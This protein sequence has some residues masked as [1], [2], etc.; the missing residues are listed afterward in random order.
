MADDAR[1]NQAAWDAWSVEYRAPNRASWS[2][3][4]ERTWGIWALPE[5]EVRVLGDVAGLDVVELGCGGA[6]WSAWLARHGAR[7]VG[8]DVSPGQLANAREFQR[9]LGPVFP[10]V[11]ADAASVPLRDRCADLVL[12]EYGAC[13]WV[14]PAR[15]VPEAARVLRPGGRLVFLTNSPLLL[16]CFPQDAPAAGTTLVRDY[17]DLGRDENTDGSVEHH[18][19]HGEWIRLLRRHGFVVE[20]LIEIRAPAHAGANRFGF[21]TAE[22]ARRWPS[23]EIWKARK[24]T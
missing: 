21:V 6:Y 7:P 23:E 11:R 22:W 4:A 3:D 12:S 2:P 16:V 8:V 13:L 24:A 15:W 5:R 14:D 9:E 1:R 10:L 18:L 19:P 17:F 20:D